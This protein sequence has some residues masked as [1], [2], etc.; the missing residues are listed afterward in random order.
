MT[1]VAAGIASLLLAAFS[2]TL[3]HTPPKPATDGGR[4]FA[5][6]E[7]MKLLNQPFMLVLFVA[8]FIDAAVHAGLFHLD[9]RFPY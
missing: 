2:L 4:R 9:R 1:Y 8:T 3:P 5:W 7:A 6:L